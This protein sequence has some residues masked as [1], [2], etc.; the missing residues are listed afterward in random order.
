PTAYKVFNDGLKYS[1][2]DTTL[3]YYSG[4][5]AIQNKD[6]ENAIK[7]YNDLLAYPTFSE[8]N[9]VLV[10]LPKLYI[11]AQDTANALIFAAKAAKE[12]PDNNDAAVQNIELNISAGKAAEIIKDIE[13]QI[14]K[15]SNNKLLNY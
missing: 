10:D 13:A 1:P 11:S 6:Y 15:D 5:A 3:I 4:I 7:K 8:Y 12:L 14:A 2:N 9:T